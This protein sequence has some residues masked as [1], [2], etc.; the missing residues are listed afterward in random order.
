MYVIVVYDVNVNRVNTIKSLLRRY[1]IWVQN[2][3]FEGEITKSQL[4]K[5]KDK[6]KEVCKKSDSVIIYRLRTKACV[7]KEVIGID[8]KL[9]SKFI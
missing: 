4:L 3:V 5:L 6:I 2:S 9:T 8:K 1:L 7:K